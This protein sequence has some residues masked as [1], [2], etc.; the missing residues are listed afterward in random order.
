MSV[1]L[2]LH[3]ISLYNLMLFS[4]WSLLLISYLSGN[5]SVF[6]FFFLQCGPFLKFSLNLLQYCFSLM[7]FIFCPWGMWY[8]SCQTR[9]QAHIPCI[10]GEV[11]STGQPGKPQNVSWSLKVI[12]IKNSHGAGTKWVISASSA[13]Q[14]SSDITFPQ[15]PWKQHTHPSPESGSGAAVRLLDPRNSSAVNTGLSQGS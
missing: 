15:T 4:F 1:F 12:K 2:F 11:L 8:L 6:F 3:K 5:R 10:E 13:I 9:D 14:Y 7:F